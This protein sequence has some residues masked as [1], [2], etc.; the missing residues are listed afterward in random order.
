MKSKYSDTSKSRFMSVLIGTLLVVCLFGCGKNTAHYVNVEAGATEGEILHTESDVAETQQETLEQATDLSEA[1]IL[2]IYICG[3]V[4]VPGVYQLPIGSR[5]CDAFLIAGGLT[6]EAATA[7]WNQARLLVDGEMIY[8]PTAEEVEARGFRAE[9]HD[10]Q[11]TDKQSSKSKVNINTAS[12][13]ELM[14]I[15]GIGES[16]AL[17]IIAYRQEHG[18]FSK[19]EDVTKVEGIKDGVFA[20][21]KEYIEVN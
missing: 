10:G 8:V 18:A 5:I 21:M 7:Y 13:E 17:A 4:Q 6:S 16:K 9:E 1:D 2:Y 14:T 19:I 12:K 15:P 20:K 11:E 3:A